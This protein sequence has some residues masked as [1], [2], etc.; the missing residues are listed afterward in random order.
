[1]LETKILRRILFQKNFTQ[2]E[3]ETLENKAKEKAISPTTYLLRNN[4]FSENNLY[5]SLALIID[6]P[7]VDVKNETLDTAAM[8]M[9]PRFFLETAT[10][11][12]YKKKETQ[13]FV[14][15]SQPSLINKKIEEYLQRKTGLS[16][17]WN[18]SSPN[19]IHYYIQSFFNI[20]KKENNKKLGCPLTLKKQETPPLNIS[21]RKKIQI[22]LSVWEKIQHFF[23]RN[24]GI[25]WI[26][27][28]DAIGKNLALNHILRAIDSP[29]KITY[30]F[31]KEPVL[32]SKWVQNLHDG[33]KN[34]RKKILE[35]FLKTDADMIFLSRVEEDETSLLYRIANSGR[36]VIGNFS[37]PYTSPI[38]PRE[39]RDVPTL[40]LRTEFI[41][42]LCPYCILRDTNENKILAQL[43][44]QVADSKIRTQ[45]LSSF[46]HFKAKGCQ[47]CKFTG[48]AEKILILALDESSFWQEILSKMKQGVITYNSK[49]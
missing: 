18:V 43:K 21:Q 22:S 46:Q 27:G 36:W 38:P 16:L 13:L 42:T 24:P 48:F 20:S 1:M 25:L 31:G 30:F 4:I 15:T 44:D 34:A 8:Q 11:I 7:F 47:Y 10:L 32:D 39:F 33:Q 9:I 23:S 6:L 26:T 41:P 5:E 28:P 35:G 2:T 14:A 29:N 49:W 12:G 40:I 3:F 37:T 17:R 19:S 45:F